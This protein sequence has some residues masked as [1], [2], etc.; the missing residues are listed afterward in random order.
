MLVH[1]VGLMVG[2]RFAAEALDLAG[3]ADVTI[4]PPPCPITV[5][6]TDFGHAHELIERAEASA[7]AFLAGTPARVLPLR[8][9]G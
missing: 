1:A 7:R 9:A 3:R 4:L 2:D 6:P 5:Q 8:A